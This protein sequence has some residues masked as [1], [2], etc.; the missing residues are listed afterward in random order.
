M[1][2]HGNVAKQFLNA[3][4][5]APGQQQLS[6]STR[7][8]PPSEDAIN[9]FF[10]F[11]GGAVDRAKAIK[12]IDGAGGNAMNA[13]E[14]YFNN[15]AKYDEDWQGWD[16]SQFHADRDGNNAAP[17]GIPSFTI[18]A[19]EDQGIYPGSSSAPTRPPSRRSN[20][21]TKSGQENGVIN[22]LGQDLSGAKYFGPPTRDAAYY[23][24][25]QWAMVPV[26]STARVYDNPDPPDR[27]RNK[28]NGEP[29]C[30]KPLKEMDPLP[31][32]I[33][34]LG[35]IPG[36]RKALLCE[37]LQLQNYGNNPRWWDGESA[38]VGHPSLVGD[39][40]FPQQDVVAETQRLMAFIQESDRSYGS[41]EAL[42]KLDGLSNETT[43]NI[44]SKSGDFTGELRF[45]VGW[46]AA[47]DMFGSA[48]NQNA[49]ETTLHGGD[50]FRTIMMQREM[51][52]G[53]M[54]DTQQPIYRLD[55]TM[56]QSE[57]KRTLY[58][59]IDS[60][61]W[62][63]DPTGESNDEYFIDHA[64]PV[65]VM[66]VKNK[67]TVEGAKGLG[68]QVPP[69][70]YADRYLRQ[71]AATM[72]QMRQR[73]TALRNDL[74]DIQERKSKLDQTPHPKDP[75]VILD[76]E[77]LFNSTID[78][79]RKRGKPPAREKPKN[80]GE[81]ATMEEAPAVTRWDLLADKLEKYHMKL[82]NKVRDLDEQRI[83]VEKQ[84]S[85]LSNILT[86]NDSTD[87]QLQPTE[88]YK[89]R[90]V[91]IGPAYET[92]FVYVDATPSTAPSAMEADG[93]WWR[94]EFPSHGSWTAPTKIPVTEAEVLTETS[95]EAK[96]ALLIYA[97]KSA[98]DPANPANAVPRLWHYLHNFI[99]N[100]NVFFDT[101]LREYQA[102]FSNE[103]P[104]SWNDENPPP[105]EEVV[106]ERVENIDMNE[107]RDDW[108]EDPES[109]VALDAEFS[110]DTTY[111]DLDSHSPADVLRSGRG[112]STEMSEIS[113]SNLAA[114]GVDEYGRMNGSYRHW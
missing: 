73:K 51:V 97:S 15:S 68:L 103:V 16:E 104:D 80:D 81:D 38:M 40:A 65:L 17:A 112:V 75:N 13:V 35:Q 37:H 45:L 28:E 90:G 95:D 91:G 63:G 41:V 88:L 54:E 99:L 14:E 109:P 83:R 84:M 11:T 1:I 60:Q 34:V 50:V 85:D 114:S 2:P 55:F 94:F 8:M 56:T 43:A 93:Q 89:L 46:S 26:S 4:P 111:E 71:H 5:L 49:S 58:N 10:E 76:R 48:V 78:H 61:L 64:A 86:E 66:S 70:F 67:H 102:Q 23:A 27:R 22:G 3:P 18:D 101:E 53:I 19:G 74:V 62:L 33:A 7:R 21:S 24:P 110:A 72:K 105:Y 39:G 113:S 32:L 96:E 47:A 87:S 36:A 12:F 82:Q 98:C 31:S 108:V 20:Y 59:A 44:I 42:E 6:D 57:P 100:D 30:F 29:V 25:E 69:I 9:T 107:K 77:D 92:T 79:L 52:D 106:V